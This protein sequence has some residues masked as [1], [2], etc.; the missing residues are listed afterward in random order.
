MHAKKNKKA[1]KRILTS[2]YHRSFPPACVTGHAIAKP[3][4]VSVYVTSV[5]RGGMRKLV[6]S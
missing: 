1:R 5:P 2:A 3:S 6:K 4:S